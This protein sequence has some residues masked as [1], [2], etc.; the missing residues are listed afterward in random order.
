M[1][2]LFSSGSRHVIKSVMT[3]C[4]LT[5]AGMQNVID[6][7]RN[8]NVNF[9]WKYVHSEG[10]KILFQKSYDKMNFTLMVISYEIY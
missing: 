4:I 9:C 6:D 1:T 2:S 8:N 3:T 5:F 10:D 7:V